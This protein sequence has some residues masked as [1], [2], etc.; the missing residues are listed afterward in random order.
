[1]SESHTQELAHES[2]QISNLKPGGYIELHEINIPCCST[3]ETSDPEPEFV[4]WSH[5]LDEAGLKVGLE[6]KAPGR[7]RGYLEETGF[8]NVHVKWQNWPVGTWAKGSRNKAIGRWWAED[9][10]DVTRNTGAIFTRVLG[11]KQEEVEVYAANI[12]KEINAQEKHM[13]VEM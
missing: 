1:M 11:W 7:L 3:K 6:F 9:L 10:K 2:N 4:K 13:W 5:L 12:A 8:S